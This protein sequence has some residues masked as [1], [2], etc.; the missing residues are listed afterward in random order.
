MKKSKI[1][2]VLGSAI[3]APLLPTIAIVIS[4]VVAL[5]LR[6]WLHF[7]VPSW[8]SLTCLIT[9]GAVSLWE[10][11]DLYRWFFWKCHQRTGE[12]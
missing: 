12:V 9:G 6:R 10:I 4:V 7:D 11:A 3:L 1:V 5:L 8:V 2:C